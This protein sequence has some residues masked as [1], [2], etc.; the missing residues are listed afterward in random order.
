MAHPLADK[1]V[2]ITGAS[3][4]IGRATA[5]ALAKCGAKP[6]LLARTESLLSDV[7]ERCKRYKAPEVGKFV[8]DVRNEKSVEQTMAAVLKQFGQIDVLI[9]NAGLSLNGDVDGYS[10]SDWQTVLETN[11]TGTFLTCRAV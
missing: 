2:V 8:C 7:A 1:V 11:L 5:F 9:N 3:A 4:G 6:A 10:L